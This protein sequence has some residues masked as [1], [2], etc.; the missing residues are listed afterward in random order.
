VLTDVGPAEADDVRERIRA[1]VAEPFAFGGREYRIGASI[2][3]AS[4]VTGRLDPDR[5]LHDADLEMYRVKA[6]GK[7]RVPV[8]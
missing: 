7:A 5:L 8:A 6:A 2:G 4:A 3:A 1:A